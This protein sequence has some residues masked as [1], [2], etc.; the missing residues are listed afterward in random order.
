MP[1]LRARRRRSDAAHLTPKRGWRRLGGGPDA[2]RTVH[3][4]PI[5]LAL[6]ALLAVGGL[7]DRASGGPGTPDRPGAATA[8]AVSVVA[9]GNALSSSWFCGGATDQ[10]KSGAPGELEVTNVSTGPVAGTATI[11][12]SN[13]ARRVVALKVPAEGHAT[14]RER[15]PGGAGWVGAMVNLEGGLVSV[16]Q[17]VVGRLGASST[18][19]AT[20]GSRA[21]YFTSG[22]T[23]VN[24]GVELSL[25]NPYPTDAIVDLTFTTNE[26]VE[27]PGDFQGLVVPARGMLAVNLGSHLRRR[28]RIA[29]TVT[30][31]AGRVVA[32]KTDVV[33]PPAKGQATIGSPQG[34][35]APDPA[36]PVGGVAVT[37]GA[38]SAGTLWTW[39]EGDTGN[40]FNEQYTI[41]NPTATTADVE[42]T[43]GLDLGSAQPVD[44]TV[45]P[46][47]VATVT[48]NEQ[49][50]IPAGVGHFAQVRSTNGVPVVA[51]RTLAVSAP[52]AISGLGELPGLRTSAPAWLLGAD[53][54]PG[55]SRGYLVVDNPGR[56]PVRISVT[57]VRH[58][59]TTAL[60]RLRPFTIPTGRRASILLNRSVAPQTALVVT[61]SA[62]IIVERDLYGT[63]TA[64]EVSLSPGVPFSVSS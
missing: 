31:R 41:Y 13:G 27:Q 60:P 61:G 7:I 22:A 3:R 6:V 23:L 38:P 62:P 10:A 37:L 48:S 35:D 26:G 40:G 32:W 14:V 15:V 4:V 29:T 44:L 12:A 16:D 46:E 5:L 9:P 51:E 17:E 50:R 24:A 33:T 58:G 19:C 36:A 49:A 56:T 11:V 43:I 21:W 63:R 39:P 42:L 20:S 47:S 57:A 64:R 52:S 2:D 45:A 18:P 34:A 55:S 30:A 53:T 54:A 25:L 1:D 8:G 28:Q 59:R